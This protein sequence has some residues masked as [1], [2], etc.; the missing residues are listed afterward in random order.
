MKTGLEPWRTN[1]EPWNTIK[2]IL[3][4]W[5]PTKTEMEPWKINL[6]PSKLTRSCRGWFWVVQVVT[7]D[8]QEEVIIFR[9]R[10]TDRHFIIIYISSSPHQHD[11]ILSIAVEPGEQVTTT[12]RSGRTHYISTL[13][14]RYLILSLSQLSSYPHPYHQW[15]GLSRPGSLCVQ[16]R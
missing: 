7:G 14:I 3:N 2:T 15:G 6:E 8:S 11:C 4:H 12:L 9:D 1:L 5:K 13:D 10:Q 16:G